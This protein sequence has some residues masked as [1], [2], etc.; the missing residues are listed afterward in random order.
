MPARLATTDANEQIKEVV[1]SGPYKFV[2]AEWQPGNQV[3]YERFADYVP[4]NEAPIGAAGG[5]RANV[6]RVI[7]RYI[8]DAGRRPRRWR[9]A[10]WT[11]GTTR[12]SISRRDSR[13]TR[14]SPCS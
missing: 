13:R 7:A 14:T 9:R 10:R 12:P 2:K 3:V 11:G 1:G 4:R 8:P 6:D 5:K